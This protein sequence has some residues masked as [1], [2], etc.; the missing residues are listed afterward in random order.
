MPAETE[1][2][3]D[4]NTLGIKAKCHEPSGAWLPGR[5][6]YKWEQVAG[7]QS[8]TVRGWPWPGAWNA[9]SFMSQPS[10]AAR[11]GVHRQKAGSEAEGT[12][13]EDRPRDGQ[14]LRHC[15]KCW[16]PI[17]DF[18]NKPLSCPHHQLQGPSE[19]QGDVRKGLTRGLGRAGLK[20]DED[21]VT[22]CPDFPGDSTVG[23]TALAQIF[24][25]DGAHFQKNYTLVRL[26]EEPRLGVGRE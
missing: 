14:S 3:Q 21:S 5:T 10:P 15:T 22:L 9:V 18:E 26:R 16:P 24:R 11:W 6:L 25:S 7:R 12:G 8:A 17:T 23:K 2:K 1:T 4:S 13:L 19:T 20:S